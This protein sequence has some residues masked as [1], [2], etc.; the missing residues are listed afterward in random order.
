MTG[1]E[2]NEPLSGS[3]AG[4]PQ[5]APSPHL[6]YRSPDANSKT[7]SREDF[8]STGAIPGY[9]R[10]TVVPSPLLL[11]GKRAGGHDGGVGVGAPARRPRRY[12]SHERATGLTL[13]VGYDRKQTA[14][15]DVLSG[16]RLRLGIGI[17]WNY[18]EYDALGESF[19]T[20]GRRVEEQIEHT[21]AKT[22]ESAHSADHIGVR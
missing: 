10:L 11:N 15:V 19:Q 14:E 1:P 22:C 20:R 8:P 21:A 16:G 4:S 5:A 3:P 6:G 9:G 2:A 13:R 18:V 7:G 17:G 12:R